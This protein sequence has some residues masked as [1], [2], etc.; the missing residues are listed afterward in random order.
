MAELSNETRT[1]HYPNI[2]LS[3]PFFAFSPLSVQHAYVVQGFRESHD[4]IHLREKSEKEKDAGGDLLRL[5]PVPFHPV[6]ILT[7]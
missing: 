2:Y 1:R 4:Q 6:L 7:R 5:F 3:L